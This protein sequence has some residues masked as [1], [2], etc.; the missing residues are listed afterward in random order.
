VD[1]MHGLFLFAVGFVG[2]VVG[3]QVL[4]RLRSRAMIGKAVPELPGE[5]GR[6]V[7]H[8]KRAL[9]YFFSPSC[10]ACRAI[11]PVV[12]KLKEHNPSVFAVDVTR[13]LSLA[14]ALNVMATPSTVEVADGAIVGFHVGMLPAQVV[15]RFS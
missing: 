1:F 8:S 11:T 4:V 2:L 15:A 5:V 14:R 7:S 10:G 9:V 6:K 12:Q 3:M 13:D